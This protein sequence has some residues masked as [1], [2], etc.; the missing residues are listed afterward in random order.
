MTTGKIED[1]YSRYAAV[2]HLRSPSVEHGYNHQNPL[3]IESAIQA[4]EIDDKI[5][6]AW[7]KHPRYRVIESA[8]SFL[9]KADI[10][11]KEIAAS[12]PECCRK[13]VGNASG[14]KI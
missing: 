4:K 11:L 5:Q 3:R 7:S 10:A 6:S 2:I 14:I 12:L 9:A 13:V 1:E 8:P